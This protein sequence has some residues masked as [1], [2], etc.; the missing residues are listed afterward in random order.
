MC[1]M[2][3]G[4]VLPILCSVVRIDGSNV[5]RIDRERGR[6]LCMFHVASLLVAS[7]NGFSYFFP[8][9]AAAQGSLCQCTPLGE[10]VWGRWL[11]APF[12][13]AELRS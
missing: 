5:V 10:G 11:G 12:S 13:G 2:V 4:Y 9:R 6:E 7:T 1:Y 8:V 3:Y